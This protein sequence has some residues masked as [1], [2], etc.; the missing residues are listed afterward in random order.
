MKLGFHQLD[1]RYEHLTR[2]AS[3]TAAAAVGI[4]GHFGSASG[5]RGRRHTGSGEPLLGM[6]DGDKRI[7][8]LEQ[9]GTGYGRGKEST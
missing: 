9:P 7:V 4:A 1:R 5:Q 6:I 8:A 3:E 2:S